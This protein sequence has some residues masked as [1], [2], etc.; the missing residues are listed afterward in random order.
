MRRPSRPEGQTLV[1]FALVLPVFLLV[2]VGILDAGR[3]VYT[4]STLSQAAR[5]GARLA[6]VE[7]GCVGVDPLPPGAVREPNGNPGVRVCPSGLAQLKVHIVDAVDR[8][9]VS[10]GPIA[11]VHF[12]CNEGTTDDPAPTG[13]WTETVGGNGC[14]D[15]SGAS[16]GA[17]GDLISV[18]VE[19]TYQPITPII[20]PL[21]GPITLSGSASVVIN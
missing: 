5:E 21:L 11:A 6:S 13:N 8:M 14:D 18:R 16:L 17:R 19:H 20:E 15:G 7:A 10:V 1:E 3:A 9:T 4:N 12:S 2:V